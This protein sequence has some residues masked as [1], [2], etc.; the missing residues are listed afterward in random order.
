VTLEH[1]GRTT[2]A[3]WGPSPRL[4][5]QEVFQAW[6]TIDGGAGTAVYRFLGD[7]NE[8]SFLR[9]DV[10]NLAYAI[11]GL[12]TGAVIGVGGGR[13]LLSARL[14]GV[15][16]VVGVEINPIFI[17]LLRRRLRGYTAVARVPGVGF[18]I[19][20]AR[21]WFARTGRSF[22]VIQMSLIDTWAA[23]GA[24]A[25]T[26]SENGL[27]TVEA[28]TIFLRRLKPGGVFTVSRWYG[29]GELDETGRMVSLAVATLQELGVQD[30][31]RH[32]FVASVEKIATLIVSPTP[33]SDE[34]LS[35][36]RGAAE[37]YDY[38][39]LIDPRSPAASP[40]LQSIVAAP[41]RP[42]LER[43]VDASYL[44]L[45]PPTDARPFFFNQLRLDKL[46]GQDLRDLASRPGVYGGNLTAT[47]T[48]VILILISL[49][50]VVL[51]IVVPLRSTVS[52]AG[53]MLA[54]AGTAYFA[55][56]GVGFMMAEIG[57]LQRMSV[58]LGHPVYALSVVLF[59]LILSTGL[60][61]FASERFPLDS[62]ARLG[63]WSLIATAYLLVLPSWLPPVLLASESAG[64]LVRAGLAIA[65]LLPAG[66]LMGFGFPTGMR[67]VS[68]IDH[69]PTP[70]FW[71]INGAAGVLAAGIAVLTS[72]V[73]GIDTTLRIGALCYLLLLLPGVLLAGESAQSA[74][75]GRLR[76]AAA[77]ASGKRTRDEAA[78]RS[79]G[80]SSD[81]RR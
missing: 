35:A 71:G 80:A 34:A 76:P 50:L 52:T 44:D 18:E 40:L 56:I 9:Y 58:F 1:S 75:S 31:K 78:R 70:W 43:A 63:A 77:H 19:D 24:G 73:F 3:L 41:D 28:W 20:E 54:V 29:P 64:L 25:F 48:L 62:R 2:P 36:L 26:L 22:D 79:A 32:L 21:S 16:E 6:L 51:T 38:K 60:G 68:A 69:R 11:P 65:V 30:P 61:S 47:L 39:V 66:F 57:L 45:T 55:L 7:L 33:L 17:D 81:E 4:P 14:F 15:P 59:S 27:Y 53:P 12:A 8:V 13:D 46:V 23:T 49:I 10:T 67:L 74:S 5:R 37:A 72:I 42:A